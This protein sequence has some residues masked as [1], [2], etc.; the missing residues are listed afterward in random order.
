MKKNVWMM[1]GCMAALTIATTGCNHDE[2]AETTGNGTFVITASTPTGADT[3]LDYKDERDHLKITWRYNLAEPEYTD[4]IYVFAGDNAQ[5]PVQFEVKSL[6]ADAHNAT[7]GV[8]SGSSFSTPPS[9]TKLY[10]FY[11]GFLQPLAGTLNLT[12]IP[13]NLTNQQGSLGGLDSLKSAHSM[14]ATAIADGTDKIKFSFSHVTAMIKLVLT[15]SDAA[16]GDEV[17]WVGLSSP[18]IH[19][20]ATLNMTNGQITYDEQAKGNITIASRLIVP[21]PGYEMK[22]GIFTLNENKATTVWLS[23]FPESLTNVKVIAKSKDQTINYE[24]S[25]DD[26]TLEAGRMY[27]ATATLTRQP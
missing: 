11:Q 21:R 25:L 7:F 24:G 2:L 22:I 23:V 4:N 9:N 14:Y 13:L 17:G 5:T 20:K 26:I 15:F 27:T 3:R 10:A 8:V 1:A 16:P 19:N 6:G 18:D 12:A